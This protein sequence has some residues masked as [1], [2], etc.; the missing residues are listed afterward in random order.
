M[1][2]THSCLKFFCMILSVDSW[3]SEEAR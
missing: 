1:L 2:R 3:D